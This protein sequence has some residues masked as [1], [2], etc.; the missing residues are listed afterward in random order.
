MKIIGLGI[1]VISLAYLTSCSVQKPKASAS[2]DQKY[3][4]NKSEPVPGA[5]IMIEQEPKNK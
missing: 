4:P 2:P 3:S 1:L 5:E